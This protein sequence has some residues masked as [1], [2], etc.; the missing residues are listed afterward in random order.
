MT[1]EILLSRL[2]KVRS[3]GKDAWVACCPAHEDSDPSM[4][5]AERDGT[6][7]MHCFAGCSVQEICSAVGLEVT[8]LFPEREEI[9]SNVARR[10]RKPYFPAEAVLTALASEALVLELCLQVLGNQG[11]LDPQMKDRALLA[12]QR[13]HTAR[14]E[15]GLV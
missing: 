12:S 15:A 2:H 14:H 8:D 4:T 13:F 10:D 6:V 7:L 1:A 9:S 5:I 3:R 11:V